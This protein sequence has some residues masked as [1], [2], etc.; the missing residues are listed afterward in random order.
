MAVVER[1]VDLESVQ[2]LNGDFDVVFGDANQS[3]RI[4]EVDDNLHYLRRD[5]GKKD[6]LILI[7]RV[8]RV[9]VKRFEIGTDGRQDIAIHRKLL[10]VGCYDR[11]VGKDRRLPEVV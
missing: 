5:V 8:Q 3:A 4:D 1:A 6:L 7:L 2:C 11:G 10:E 9:G